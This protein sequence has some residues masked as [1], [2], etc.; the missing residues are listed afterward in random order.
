MAILPVNKYLINNQKVD[1]YNIKVPIN[2]I[3][4]FIISN[5]KL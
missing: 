4:I 5:K 3:F 2:Y 1:E